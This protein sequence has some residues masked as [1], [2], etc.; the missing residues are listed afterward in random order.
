[1]KTIEILLGIAVCVTL[2]SGCD[3]SENELDNSTV[4]DPTEAILGKWELVALEYFDGRKEAYQPKGYT[5]YLP[6]SLTGWYDY[7]TRKYEVLQGKYRLDFEFYE[8]DTVWYL[9]YEPVQLDDEYGTMYEYHPDMPPGYNYDINFITN[10]Q[11]SLRTNDIMSLV[12]M[13][14]YFYKRKK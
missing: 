9:H 4:T 7:T 1:M 6:D 14:V 2:L 8:T 13:P 10:N 11:M 12:A 5:E 3:K